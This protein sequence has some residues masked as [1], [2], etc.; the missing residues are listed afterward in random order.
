MFGY[1]IVKASGESMSPTILNGAYLI[2]KHQPH[3]SIDDVIHVR[4]TH[5]GNM[6]KRIVSGDPHKGFYVAGDNASSLSIE[7]IGLINGAQIFGKVSVIINPSI[8]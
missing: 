3:Y 7:Q 6:V 2:V 1:K 8:K 5:Y 4:H